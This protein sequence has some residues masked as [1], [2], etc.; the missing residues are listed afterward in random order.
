MGSCHRGEDKQAHP[1]LFNIFSIDLEED[2]KTEKKPVT[3]QLGAP[4]RAAGTAANQ[5]KDSSLSRPSLDH[6]CT[7][8]WATQ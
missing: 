5:T 4:A 3:P 6:I 8:F 2:R 1:A 7:P